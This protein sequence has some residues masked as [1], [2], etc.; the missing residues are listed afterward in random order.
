MGSVWSSTIGIGRHREVPPLP[1]HPVK[2]KTLP[3]AAPAWT[4][5]RPTNG[6]GTAKRWPSDAGDGHWTGGSGVGPARGA[7]FPGAAMAAAT[8]ATAEH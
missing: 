6:T 5:P 4:Q 3:D 8:R 2:M 7:P 1:H